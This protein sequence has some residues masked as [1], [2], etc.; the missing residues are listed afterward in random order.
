MKPIRQ[1]NFGDAVAVTTDP[2]SE[3]LTAATV[4]NWLKVDTD[5]DDTLIT[6]LIVAARE[7]V[8]NYTGIKLFTQTIAETWDNIPVTHEIHSQFGGVSLS[9]FPVQSITSVQYLDDNGDTQT[10]D[11]ANYVTDL[12]S[13]PARVAPAFG[14]NWPTMRLQMKALTITYVA[15]YSSV[16]SI[17]DAIKT[18][19][20][21]MIT[22]WYDNRTDAVK[23]LPTASEAILRPYK[24]HVH[25]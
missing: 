25:V 20:Q 12:E 11:S 14:A 8:E 23:N 4:K 21:L 7:A 13:Y 9:T 15:G 19:M 6:S 1:F 16:D 22:Y 3:P 5:A 18:A 17:P 24:T 10:W 2:A